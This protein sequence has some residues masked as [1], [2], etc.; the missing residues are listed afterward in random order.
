MS[1]YHT[2]HDTPPEQGMI[3]QLFSML[4]CLYTATAPYKS[5]YPGCNRASSINEVQQAIKAKYR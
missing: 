2:W 3:Y 4:N 5:R 1:K